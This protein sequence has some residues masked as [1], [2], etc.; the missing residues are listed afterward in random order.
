MRL[1][2]VDEF[3]KRSAIGQTGFSHEVYHLLHLAEGGLRILILKRGVA[4]VIS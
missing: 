2:R 3:F 1:K 4:V